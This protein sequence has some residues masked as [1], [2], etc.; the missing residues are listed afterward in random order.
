MRWQRVLVGAVPAVLVLFI[1]ASPSAAQDDGNWMQVTIVNVLP[2][3]LDDYIELQLRDVN[4]ALQRA[5]VPWRSVWQTAEFG[6]TYERLF[7][8]PIASLSDF[9]T[10]GPLASG[11]DPDDRRKLLD[12]LR[13]C[14][15]SRQTYAVRY[16]PDLSVVADSVASRFLSRVSTIQIAPGRNG[17]WEDFL[18]GNLENF[19]GAKVAFGV[20][21][22]VFG[23]GPTTW[24]IIQNHSSFV[25][26]NEPGIIGRAFGDRADTVAARLAGIVQSI[27]RTVLRRDELL[28]YAAVAPTSGQ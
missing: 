22:R 11:M 3:K 2:E 28:S 20:Y 17:E 23:P 27:E 5:G 13:R 25:A 21:Q 12:R 16:R 7:V 18:W 26:L 24:Q 9:D 14:T 6:N 1:L 8:T 10:G 15:V 4:P 19:E